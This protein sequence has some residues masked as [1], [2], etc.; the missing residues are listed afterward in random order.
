MAW[1]RLPCI[2]L[3]L[4]H[5]SPPHLPQPRHPR[6]PH[7]ISPHLRQSHGFR[8]LHLA[9]VLCV[10]VCVCV[11]VGV[12][13]CVCMCE[14]F[15]SFQLSLAC[16]FGVFL[17]CYT[18]VASTSAVAAAP[19]GLSR[20]CGRCHLPTGNGLYCLSCAPIAVAQA[21]AAAA[22]EPGARQVDVGFTDAD[23]FLLV[24]INKR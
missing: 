23:G 12:C 5:G 13:V 11:C 8:R 1:L 3:R 17:I 4:F 24:Q 21:A 10:C 20:P 6:F 16:C 22:A 7:H 14:A 18:F 15:L 9:Q 2:L 19:A